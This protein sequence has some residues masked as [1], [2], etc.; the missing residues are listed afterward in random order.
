MSLQELLSFYISSCVRQGSDE[1]EMLSRLEEVMQKMEPSMRL[2]APSQY[3]ANY[4][5][6]Q[7]IQKLERVPGNCD[8]S[9]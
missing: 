1:I 5:A 4:K 7:L 6:G 3:I 8:S 2:L 9:C